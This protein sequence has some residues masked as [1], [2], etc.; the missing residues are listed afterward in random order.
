MRTFGRAL[1]IVALLLGFYVLCALLIIVLII[2]DVLAADNI[3]NVPG[4]G[5]LVVILVIATVSA[6]IIVIRGVFVSTRVKRK[7]LPGVVVPP[8][9][10]PV[11]WQHVRNLAAAA[12]T[13]PPAEIRLVT[14]VNAAVLEHAH[15]FG[16]LPG[17]RRMLIGVPFLLALPLPQFDAVIGHELGHYSGRDVRLGPLTARAREGVTGALRAVAGNGTKRGA[18]SRMPGS[19][20]FAA[21]FRAYASLVFTQTFAT[22]RRQEFAAD[23]F[24]ASIAGRAN[25]AIAIGDIPVIHA[26]Y[27]FYLNRYVT[28]GL[29]LGFAPPPAEIIGG[30]RYLVEDPTRMAEIAELRENPR[31][32]KTHKW[33]SHPPISER[34][35]AIMALPD[36][37]RPVDTSGHR[38]IE[39]LANPAVP[40]AALGI[41]L[42]GDK[43]AGKTA[44]DWETA[45]A[46]VGAHAL[47]ERSRL[48][49][50]IV[51][52]TIGRPARLTDFLDLVDAGRLDE[53][54]SQ[55]PRSEAAKKVN[56]TGRAAREFSKTQ[57]ASMLDAWARLELIGSGRARI[58]HSWSDTLGRLD[59]A[60][61][62]LAG[63]SAGIDAVLATY[64]M[65]APLRAALTESG[66]PA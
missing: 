60:P 65:T 17:K 51:R 61:G 46:H 29:P 27:V 2:L 14:D 16:L 38:A 12:G 34:V 35:A 50:D 26:A 11:L 22:S 56:A 53:M 41:T 10:E 43:A 6:I 62:T 44:V 23:R 21:I 58:R 64:P 54:L 37:G 63:L 66:I 4:G 8:A 20:I 57:L 49:V 5:R 45:A 30:F 40:L 48:I 18:M 7:D 59:A 39:L 32:E 1:Q 19:D 36:D 42:L 24:A 52:I 31:P 3:G 33:D 25:A 13:R 15:L 55:I 28:A 47:H 9:A